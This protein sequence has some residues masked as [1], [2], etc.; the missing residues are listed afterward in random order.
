MDNKEKQIEEFSKDI[1]KACVPFTCCE[2]KEP[3]AMSKREAE[4]YFNLGYRKASDVIK[5]FIYEFSEEICHVE[6]IHFI[7]S[8]AVLYL[9]GKLKQIGEK[10]ICDT[11]ESK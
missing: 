8:P 7:S 5:E 1:C 3:C 9:L 2:L 11:E 6:R 4:I 10:Y